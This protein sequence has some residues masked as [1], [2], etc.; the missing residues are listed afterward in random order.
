[1]TEPRLTA[2]IS[3][4]KKMINAYNN[5]QDLYAVIAQS[6]FDNDYGQN[7]E[8]W[9]EGTEL[10]ID[11]KNVVSGSG[12]EKEFQ[13]DDD[14]SITCPYYYLVPTPDGDKAA[15]ELTAGDKVISD[16]GQL[17]VKTVVRQDKQVTICFY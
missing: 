3:Q 9:P 16:I 7:L 14:N 8:F 4:D 12:A 6:A 1:M 13:T 10:E 15:H 2:F 17:I 11:G 5:K